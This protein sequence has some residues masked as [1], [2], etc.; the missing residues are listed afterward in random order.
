MD[1]TIRVQALTG[2]PPRPHSPSISVPTAQDHDPIS[3]ARRV[4]GFSE[5]ACVKISAP[6]CRIQLHMTS[7]SRRLIR[8]LR[9]KLRSVTPATGGTQAFVT[10]CVGRRRPCPPETKGVSAVDCIGCGPLGQ[11][12]GPPTSRSAHGGHC[13]AVARTGAT[14]RRHPGPAGSLTISGRPPVLACRASGPHP[15]P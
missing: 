10:C 3:N 6:E 14:G 5:R 9:A 12:T 2:P 13:S 7:V 15:P 8:Q 4:G 1:R 11:S